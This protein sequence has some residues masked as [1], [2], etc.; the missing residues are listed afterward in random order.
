MRQTLT[1]WQSSARFDQ[2]LVSWVGTT[3]LSKAAGVAATSN[4]REN[5]LPN[6]LGSRRMLS[7]QGPMHSLALYRAKLARFRSYSSAHLIRLGP[8]MWRACRVRAATS[9][10]SH[11]S[12]RRL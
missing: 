5:M 10:A 6:S 1:A 11:C 12:N 2:V 9:P 8:D 4:V 7:S 3:L